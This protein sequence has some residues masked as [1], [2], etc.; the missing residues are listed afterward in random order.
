MK[1]KAPKANKRKPLASARKESWIRGITDAELK[2][3][4][5]ERARAN[6]AA[7]PPAKGRAGTKAVPGFIFMRP[8]CV[9]V[10]C[11]DE[12]DPDDDRPPRD[13]CAGQTWVWQPDIAAQLHTGEPT[14]RFT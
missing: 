11:H 4:L 1:R 5:A 6:P 12:P 9:G 3:Q 2:K 7:A 14:A 10:D 13:P 8:T